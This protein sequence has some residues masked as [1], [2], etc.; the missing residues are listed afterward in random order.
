MTSSPN[1]REAILKAARTIF[2]R[3]G[4]NGASMESI[5]EEAPVSK[6]TL[7]SHFG[8]KH[9]LFVAV[10]QRQCSSLV[11][12]LDQATTHGL[13]PE[14]GIRTIAESFVQTI[15]NTESLALYRLIIAE[16]H[17]CPELAQLMDST[18]IQPNLELLS[19]Y[20]RTLNAASLL[21]I[22]DPTASG[23]LLLGMLKGIPH[24]RCLTG[25]QER[26]SAEEEKTL[27]DAA[28]LHFLKGH[29]YAHA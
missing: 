5:A 2:V 15:Y 19:N 24:F 9:E 10:I 29:G 4:Y 18:V 21:D 13:A 8:S 25:L 22:P 6:P 27:I 16:H 14:T 20:L 3:A 12:S 1:K 17:H 11:G 23:Q 26:L 28:V 7:Y